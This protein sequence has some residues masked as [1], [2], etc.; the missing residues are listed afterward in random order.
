MTDVTTPYRFIPLSRLIV[1]PAWANQV[2]H[3]HPLADGLCGEL[4]LRVTTHTPL[5]V[6]GEQDSATEREPGRVH[7]FR[8]PDGR[9]AI[10]GTSLKGMLRNVLEIASFGRFRQVEDQQLGVR[11][12]SDAKNFYCQAIVRRQVR[13]GWLRFLDGRWQ[14]QPCPFS[15][16]HQ[17]ELISALRIDEARWKRC[18]S[19]PRR[20]EL[21]GLCPALRFERDGTMP[22]N[23]QQWR[24]KPSPQGSLSGR[25]VVTGQPG[26]DYTKPKAKKFEFIFH[27][28]DAEAVEVAP[29][30]MNGFRQIHEE[31]DEWKF[32]SH[33]LDA[34]QLP[35]GI[36]VFYHDDDAG[37]VVSLGLAMMYKLPYRHSIHEA[38]AHTHPGHL[39]G[40]APDLADLVFGYLGDDNGGGLRGRVNIGLGVVEADEDGK[41]PEPTL[42]RA[43]ILNGPKATFYPAYIRQDGRGNGFRTLMDSTA[44]VS[45]WKRYPLKPPAFPTINSKAAENAKVQVRL[46]TVPEGTRFSTRL[47]F[48]NLRPVELGALLWAVDF[49]GRIDRRHGLGMGKPFGLGQV[50]LQVV[51][52]RIRSNHPARIATE[53]ES[54][55]LQA[56]RLDFID[57]MDGVLRDAGQT[58]GWEGSAPV[59][60][61]LEH[62][63]PAKEPHRFDYLPEPKAFVELRRNNALSEV[64]ATL[65]GHSPVIPEKGFEAEARRDHAGRIGENL[66]RAADLLAEQAIARERAQAKAEQAERKA[67]ATPEAKVLLEIEELVDAIESGHATGTQKKK[68]PTQLNEA[69]RISVDMDNDQKC[70]LIAL[71]QRAETI[72]DKVTSKT[73]KKIL[74]DLAPAESAE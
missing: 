42:N 23:S 5:C 1:L 52:H 62:A 43:C 73:V 19:A 17:Q 45:G 46:E 68:L 37:A 18:A 64:K 59:Q 25:V 11:D 41:T 39:H 2:S 16:L 49:G 53:D 35:H 36:P 30:V 65:H 70:L 51:A 74:R 60:A 6:G 72:D 67:A 31:A 55:L 44:E 21:I 40:D 20:Y 28:T 69:Q 12:L 63:L 3:D 10:P 7:F 29:A 4:T 8:S 57:F 32:W 47:R 26:P 61:L 54:L 24:A 22:H 58:E 66:T 56:C 14:I 33:K 13:A 50:S 71:A 34:G 38:I 9:P 15:R 27:D 48:H